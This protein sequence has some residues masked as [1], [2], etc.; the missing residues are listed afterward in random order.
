[1]SGRLIWDEAKRRANLSKH[2]LDFAD[3]TWVLES[4]I[5]MD[6]PDD[7]SGEVRIRSF[8]YVYVRLKALMVVHVERGDDTQIVS[9]RAASTEERNLYYEW[10]ETDD[11]AS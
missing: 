7:T 10:L 2:G 1:M 11:D 3:A 6:V 9:F 4:E 8:A 5:R